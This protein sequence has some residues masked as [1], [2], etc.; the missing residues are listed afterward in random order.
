MNRNGWTSIHP[1]IPSPPPQHVFLG[2]KRECVKR[3]RTASI[4]NHHHFHHHFKI[5][6]NF[7]SSLCRT[8]FIFHPSQSTGTTYVYLRGRGSQI[9]LPKPLF[10]LRPCKR[11]NFS[12]HRFPQPKV[13]V[14]YATRI[15][16]NRVKKSASVL[17]EFISFDIFWRDPKRQKP[18]ED[19]I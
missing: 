5:L 17:L 16:L 8:S 3:C 1:A 11:S 12:Y 15:Q 6:R 19:E 13:G 2:W 4:T 10:F 14:N 7:L 18:L 9:S